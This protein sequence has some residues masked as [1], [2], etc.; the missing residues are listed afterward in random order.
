MRSRGLALLWWPLVLVFTGVAVAEQALVVLKDG[1]R[2]V[3]DITQTETEIV[4]KNAAG[5]IRLARDDVERIIPVAPRERKPAPDDETAARKAQDAEFEKLVAALPEDDVNGHFVLAQWAQDRGR[6]DLVVRQCRHVLTLKPNHAEARELLKKAE[7]RARDAGSPTGRRML[8]RVLPLSDRDVQRLRLYEFPRE[9]DPEKVRVKFRKKGNEPELAAVVIAELERE[10]ALDP[11][12]RR[13]LEK[14][15]PH[16][17][18]QAILQTTDMKHAD[19]IEIESDLKVFDSFRRRVLPM[20]M[21]GCAKSGCHGGEAAA[22]FRVPTQGGSKEA[23]AHT[24]FVILDRMRTTNGALIDREA[25]ADSLLLQY[26]LPASETDNPHPPMPRAHRFSPVI[27][28][29]RDPDYAMILDWI[30]SLRTP[31]PTY[32]LEYEFPDWVPA[33][34]TQPAAK[35]AG[36]ATP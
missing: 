22:V 29:Q 18:L 16:E 25:P 20:V 23:L 13:R 14:G 4:L 10:G 9:G 26:M 36:G 12:M 28:N 7:A 1:R 33:A 24:S 11:T 19:R 2:L 31:H 21:A 30:R 17:Q 5:E 32:E 34:T 3:G 15:R 27:Q 6:W 8:P 35:S